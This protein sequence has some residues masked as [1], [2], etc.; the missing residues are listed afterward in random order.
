M[1]TFLPKN[2]KKLQANNINYVLKNPNTGHFHTRTKYDNQLI[3]YYAFTGKISIVGQ[4]QKPRG[5]KALLEIL[6]R[7]TKNKKINKGGTNE[8]SS[9]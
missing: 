5:I 2:Q 4:I 8:N 9:K 1:K 6:L 7:K 3:E